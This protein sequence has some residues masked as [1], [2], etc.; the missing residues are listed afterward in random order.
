MGA[1]VWNG[2]AKILAAHN[3][4][5]ALLTNRKK[6][7]RLFG[8]IDIGFHGGEKFLLKKVYCGPHAI[9]KA[10]LRTYHGFPP[11][12]GHYLITLISMREVNFEFDG[13][14]AYITEAI[15]RG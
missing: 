14:I 15:N 11:V 9:I 3:P 10:A 8:N 6:G 4:R 2:F 1:A 7:R 12:R 5:K 13:C